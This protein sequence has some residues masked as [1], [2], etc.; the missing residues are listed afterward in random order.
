MKTL[1]AQPITAPR[2]VIAC[3]ITAAIATSAPAHGALRAEQCVLVYN[4]RGTDSREL[5]EYYARQRGVP[6]EHLCAIDVPAREEVSRRDYDRA[7]KAIRT[8]LERM[9]GGEDIACLVTFYD[10]PLRVARITPDS[11]R[12]ALAERLRRLQQDTI[13]RVVVATARIESPEVFGPPDVLAGSTMPALEEELRRFDDARR[14]AAARLQG[15]EGIEHARRV[16]RLASLVESVEGKKA[17]IDLL[18]PHQERMSPEQKVL[19]A[20]L[21]RRWAEAR[22]TLERIGREGVSF[23]FFE[24]FLP[25]METWHGTAG[26]ARWLEQQE[27]I[28][29]GVESHAAFDSEL[30]CLMWEPYVLDRWQLNPL[31]A[32]V[33]SAWGDQ[34]LPRTLMVARIDAPTPQIARRMIDDALA[35][36]KE[37][38]SGVCYLDLRAARGNGLDVAF[39]RDLAELGELLRTR[40]GMPVVVDRGPQV[41]A[42]GTCPNAALY[43]GWY[44]LENYIPAFTFRRGAVGF[45]IA[46]FE[47]VSLRNRNRRY[48]CA[49]MLRDGVCATLGPTAE[50]YLHAFPLPSRFFGYL[51]TGEYTLVECYYR[52]CPLLSWQMALLGDPLYRPF[53]GRAVLKEEDVQALPSP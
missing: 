53:A 17:S 48:W 43:C 49:E 21:T 36:E 12:R 1:A 51:L 46:S 38:L 41:F 26:A 34:V 33:R 8:F 52:S 31:N 7:A 2:C 19:F 45:H 18:S 20:E 40:E 39:D 22:E 30:S 37:G 25:L 32:A 27:R 42:P 29:S 11:D 10:V 50:P 13:G 6:P 9:P 28:V 23:V 3:V 4:Q 24:P 35:V 5:A 15:G 16:A 47:L 44:S 14:R